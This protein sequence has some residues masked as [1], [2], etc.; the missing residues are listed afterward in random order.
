MYFKERLRRL[1]PGFFVEVGSGRGE[2]SRLLLEHGWSGIAFDLNPASPAH[3]EDINGEFIENGQFEI[4]PANWLDEE[5]SRKA[6][7]IVS[8]M[9]LEHLNEKD[10]ARYFEK[11][12]RELSDSGVMVLLV[13][14]GKQYWGIEDEIAGHFRRYTRDLLRKQ[15]ETSGFEVCHIAGLTFPVSNLLI[16]LSELLVKRAEEKKQAMTMQQKTI[17]S[18]IRTVPFKTTF[19]WL[20][21]LVL[22]E[23]VMY[24]FYWLQKLTRGSTRAMVLYTEG[25]PFK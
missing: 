15:M 10:E 17:A 22:N 25:K 7:M 3:V 19:P 5:I 21:G 4:R 6:D 14:A 24:P 16:P 23:I 13:P 8:C 18:G 1:R 9:V 2:L 12:R 20:L 11:C